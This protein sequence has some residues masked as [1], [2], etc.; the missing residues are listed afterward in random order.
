MTKS[1]TALPAFAALLAGWSAPSFAE[2]PAATAEE[3]LSAYQAEVDAVM[4]SADSARRCP[5]NPG[6]E[7]I[8]VCARSDNSNMRVPYEPEPGA[9]VRLV[10]GEAPSSRD[11]LGAA[12]CCGGGGGLDVIAIGRTLG[13]G[14]DRLLHPY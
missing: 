3:V 9:R 11:A 8:V 2:P 13:R 10:A 6:G 1:R 12:G 7:D 5:R 4:R 14:L